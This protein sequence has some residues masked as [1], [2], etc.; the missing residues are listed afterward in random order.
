MTGRA[1]WA[2]AIAAAAVTVLL[3]PLRPAARAAELIEQWAD[4]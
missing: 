1:H 3:L 4:R 2:A